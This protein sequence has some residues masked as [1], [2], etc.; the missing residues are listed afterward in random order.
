MSATKIALAAGLASTAVALVIVLSG[1]PVAVLATNSI[2]TEKTIAATNVAASA[3]QGGERLP[4]GTR[5]IR[6][7]LGAFTGPAIYVTV[8]AGKRLVASGEHGSAWAGQ[9]VSVPIAPVPSTTQPVKVCFSARPFKGE[10]L[11]IDGSETAP[12]IAARSSQGQILPG[13]I[14]IAYLA[15]ARSSWLARA[16]SVAT[17]MG[18]GRAWSGTWIVFLVLAL[19]LTVVALTSRLTLRELDE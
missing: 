13:R 18:L 17:H 19:M 2:A 6:L 12:A 9:T 8:F 15:R 3:C 10:V 14:Q 11:E 16:S 7:S 5:T 1:S 4:Q